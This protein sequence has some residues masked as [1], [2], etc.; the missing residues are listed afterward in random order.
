[1]SY[2]IWPNLQQTSRKFIQNNRKKTS[3]FLNLFNV[4]TR[5]LMDFI[6]H[7]SNGLVRI[8]QMRDF[9]CA[10]ID[11]LVCLLRAIENKQINLLSALQEEWITVGR[12]STIDSKVLYL[13]SA[14]KRIFRNSSRTIEF[15]CQPFAKEHKSW[16]YAVKP[17]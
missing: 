12:I 10:S 13:V 16:L 11:L 5:L 1:M 14:N 4:F 2:S 15:V 7:R 9:S 6:F 8:V 17:Q 3:F